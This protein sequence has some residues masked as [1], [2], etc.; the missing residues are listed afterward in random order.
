MGH[1]Y[2]ATGDSYRVFGS[3]VQAFD[4]LPLGTYTISFDP[5]SGYSL[6][7]RDSLKAPEEKVYGKSPARVERALA[8]YALPTGRSLG[9]LMTG[10]RGMGKSLTLRLL[11]AR[12]GEVYNIPTVI[13]DTA[14]PGLANFL[15]T[16][17]ECVLVF[18]E[19]EKLFNDEDQARL[20]GLFDGLSH[21]K[22]VH[23]VTANSAAML[24]T[25]FLSRPGRFHY[26]FKFEYPS[27]SEI[28]EYLLDN[29]PNL[30]ESEVVAVQRHAMIRPL[31]YDH[32]RAVVV[33]YGLGGDFMSFIKELN[34]EQ[35][36][37]MAVML[38]FTWADSERALVKE[39]KIN[40]DGEI[41]IYFRVPLG[42]QP[43]E[44]PQQEATST[45]R[46]RKYVHISA[47]FDM[48]NCGVDEDGAPMFAGEALAK[49]NDGDADED[50]QTF[51]S[52][53]RVHVLQNG[54]RL[55]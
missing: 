31:N 25:Y 18:D 38:E 13:V 7:L 27:K 46:T 8:H 4:R 50:W 35:T 10:D 12:F 40:E 9:V 34:V 42:N 2:I 33:E 51:F 29:I 39:A 3:G 30:S 5:M 52:S 48:A 49:S 24:N 1:T 11:S 54:K 53:V 47:T 23:V 21:T 28:R 41:N 16:L 6:N 43:E 26:H 15:D 55:Y 36:G 19:F 32:L 14:T 22:R 17:G 45:G 37:N 20:L 44:A